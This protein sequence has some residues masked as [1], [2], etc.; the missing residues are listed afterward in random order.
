MHEVPKNG[1]N[2]LKR[3]P[4][5]KSRWISSTGVFPKSRS[6][7]S[8]TRPNERASLPDTL[9][10]ERK[11]GKNIP[12]PAMQRTRANRFAQRRIKHQRRLAPVADLNVNSTLEGLNPKP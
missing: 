7:G 11:L 8:Q 3:N 4:G 1:L 5:F 10:P 2:G 9:K 12:N 6:A